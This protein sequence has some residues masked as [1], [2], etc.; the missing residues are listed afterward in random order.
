MI[1]H[2]VENPQQ[3]E[4]KYQHIMNIACALIFKSKLSI[5]IR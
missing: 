4:Q 2:Q 3:N 1:I 5:I